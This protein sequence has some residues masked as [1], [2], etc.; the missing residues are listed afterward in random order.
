MCVNTRVLVS[1][2]SRATG[3]RTPLGPP[4]PGR[5][6]PSYKMVKNLH[7]AYLYVHADDSWVCLHV[8]S[9]PWIQCD[10]WRSKFR[11]CFLK[12]SGVLGEYFQP[13]VG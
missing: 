2:W 7:I 5:S 4:S 13:V 8:T 6:S 11:F 10:A 1:R 12:S 3:S 9:F